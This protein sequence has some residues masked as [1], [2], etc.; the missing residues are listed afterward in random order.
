MGASQTQLTAKV[1][2]RNARFGAAV[3]NRSQRH[4]TIDR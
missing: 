2:L 1:A 4:E 3:A